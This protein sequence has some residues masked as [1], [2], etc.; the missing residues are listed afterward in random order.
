VTSRNT[1]YVDGPDGQSE[2]VA[3]MLFRVLKFIPKE[4]SS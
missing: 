3:S 1:W 4:K 2:T